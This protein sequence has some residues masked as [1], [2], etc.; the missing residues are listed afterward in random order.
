MTSG[1]S[2]R[3][4]WMFGGCFGGR[5]GG[6]VCAV[7]HRQNDGAESHDWMPRRGRS[8]AA[9][10]GESDACILPLPGRALTHGS[11]RLSLH[12]DCE[13]PSIFE[14]FG[15]AG[16]K[17]VAES[18]NGDPDPDSDPDPDPRSQISPSPWYKDQH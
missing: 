7:P 5:F 4:W 11:S 2:L 16:K 10:W 1:N 14:V 3:F 9:A 12:T 8:F 13:S 15:S 17:S 18:R 6:E